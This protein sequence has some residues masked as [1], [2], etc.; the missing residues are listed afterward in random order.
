MGVS[1]HKQPPADADAF[2]ERTAPDKPMHPGM[3]ALEPV[4]NP[5]SF[6]EFWPGFLFYIPVAFQ[7]LWLS[8]RHRGIGLPLVA[9]P[10]IPLSGMVG[11]SKAGIFSSACGQAQ[12]KIAPWAL[13][14]DWQTPEAGT[15]RAHYLFERNALA[16]PLVAKPD[17]GCRG[18]GVQLIRNSEEL[19]AYIRAFPTDGKIVFQQLIPLRSR[20]GRFLYSLP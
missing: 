5:I 11:E 20:S 8:L 6:F 17:I 19:L 1:F 12:E 10:C 16:Y 2:I 18:A 14:E 7:W 15:E 3:P 13:L 4:R 9:N